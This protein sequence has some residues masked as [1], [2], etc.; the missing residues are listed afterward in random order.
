ML[1]KKIATVALLLGVIGIAA[2][3]LLELVL[4]N[5]GICDGSFLSGLCFNLFYRGY[6]ES[7]ALFSVALIVIS[8]ILFF[9]DKR[10]NRS[11]LIFAM[12]YTI[13]Y[14]IAVYVTPPTSGLLQPQRDLVSLWL[15]IAFVILSLILIVYKSW[16]LKKSSAHSLKAS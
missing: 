3:F 11:W 4:E 2:S 1:D 13:V 6:M 9:I 5:F 7:V 14:V 12:I 15:S 16:R 8:L 10:I